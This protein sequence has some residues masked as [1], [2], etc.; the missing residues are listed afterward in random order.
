M[1]LATDLQVKLSATET[2]ALDLVTPKAA[3]A[4]LARL[5]LATGTAVNQADLVFQD[6]RTLSASGTEDLDLKGS[7]LTPLGTAFTPAKLK[8]LLVKA[9]AGNT[10]N[11]NV[12]RPASNGV[13]LFAAAGDLIPVRPGGVFLWACADNTAVAVTAATG[14]LITITNSGSGTSVSYDVLMIGTSA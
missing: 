8:L 13:P 9:A 5:Q 4:Y 12:S 1:A 3:I 10:N 6:T 11:V 14:D 7:L 2:S